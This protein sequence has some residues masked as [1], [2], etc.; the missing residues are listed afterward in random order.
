MEKR[1]DILNQFAIISDLLE[2]ANIEAES[3]TIIIE[4]NKNEFEKIY[5]LITSKTNGRVES[6]KNKFSIKIGE[7]DFVFNM[8]NV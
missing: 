5:K 7:I 8:S 6:V 3:K 1:G 4:L 2:K